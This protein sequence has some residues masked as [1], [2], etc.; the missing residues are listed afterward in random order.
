[1]RRVAIIGA[2]LALFQV[3]PVVA[4]NAAPPSGPAGLQASGYGFALTLSDGRVLTTPDLIGAV[5][6]MDDPDG[7]LVTARIDDATPSRERPD[8]LLLG[9][10]VQDPVSKAW[11]PMC[12]ADIHGRRAAFPIP[13]RWDGQAFVK[14]KT[15]WFLTCTAGSQGKC[16]LWGYDPWGTGPNGEDLAPYYQACQHMVHADY[17]GDG[18]PHTRNGTE[19]DIW[20][21]LGIQK[22][23][24]QADP[25]FAFE[26][27]WS[28]TG[29]V[30]VARTRWPDI[31]PL[32]VLLARKPSLAASPCDAAEAGRRGAIL[33]ARSRLTG[34]VQTEPKPWLP[35]KL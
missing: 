35:G 27:G 20:D 5:L 15:S 11:G 2:V 19:F 32:D 3:T 6:E 8:I 1:M 25:A 4:A 9:L 21:N 17:E 23:E 14:D 7:R 22:P 16:I 18:E 28:P 24:T 13:G 30:C 10:S 26:A 31:L 12:G 29:A 33:F 34:K